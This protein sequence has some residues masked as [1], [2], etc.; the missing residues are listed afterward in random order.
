MPLELYF[1]LSF[2][3]LKIK[4]EVQVNSLSALELLNFVW[5]SHFCYTCNKKFYL[6]TPAKEFTKSRKTMHALR[7]QTT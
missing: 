3:N 1:F 5:L 2:M 6:T 4:I 7:N